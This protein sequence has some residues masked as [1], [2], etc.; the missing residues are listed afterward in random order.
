MSAACTNGGA[1]GL[2]VE[3]AEGSGCTHKIL[4]AAIGSNDV[5]LAAGK[6]GNFDIPI[7]RGRSSQVK[8]QFVAHVRSVQNHVLS[9]IL[10]TDDRGHLISRGSDCEGIRGAIAI[11]RASQ[12]G[13]RR[14]WTSD[15][16]RCEVE[17]DSANVVAALADFV[18]ARHLSGGIGDG[19]L[20][21]ISVVHVR[22]RAASHRH[23]TT[24]TI[25]GRTRPR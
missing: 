10:S 23:D 3:S 20:D 5:G 22:R 25:T 7:A 16:E 4:Q 6:L 8:R 11:S 21:E 1:S 19:L 24:D 14:R 9:G 17:S 2:P 15:A 18:G 12:S 13:S